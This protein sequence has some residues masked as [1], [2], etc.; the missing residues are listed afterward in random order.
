MYE[1]GNLIQHFSS[2]KKCG[3]A[4][5]EILQVILDKFEIAHIIYT[6]GPGSFMGIKLSYIILKT[7]CSI[8][9]IKFSAIS[10]FDVSDNGIIKANKNLAFILK[11]NEINMI[12]EES[13]NLFL[14]QNFNNI[15][16]HED[17]LPNYVV[18][19]I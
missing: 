16:I 18:S 13:G 19:A 14:P 3:D 5:P 6:N 10:G 9:N 2:E 4:L 11:D 15:V 7:F 17:T 8:K 1:N 12:K